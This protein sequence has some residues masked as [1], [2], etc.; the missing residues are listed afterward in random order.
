MNGRAVG[1]VV[2]GDIW[3]GSRRERGG[4]IGGSGVGGGV[5]KTVVMGGLLFKKVK[6]DEVIKWAEVE[7]IVR[8]GKDATANKVGGGLIKIS[9]GAG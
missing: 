4:G 5:T 6:V 2:G 3:G 7:T 9:A 1:E 8:E